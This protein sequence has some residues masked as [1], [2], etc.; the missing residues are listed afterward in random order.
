MIDAL[1]PLTSIK[2][3]IEG[4]EAVIEQFLHDYGDLTLDDVETALSLVG[5]SETDRATMPVKWEGWD[6]QGSSLWI[7]WGEDVINKKKP[8]RSLSLRLS[9][10]SIKNPDCVYIASTH[11]NHSPIRR[12][13]ARNALMAAA[14]LADKCDKRISVC[15]TD[16][17]HEVFP[18]LGAKRE[19]NEYLMYWSREQVRNI[20]DQARMRLG[21]LGL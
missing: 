2:R 21:K 3:N 15:P 7:G 19:G 4:D 11:S 8:G 14:Y 1:H 9:T 13:F 18:H 10:V 5:P 20:A 12:G 16:D 6:N 17:G